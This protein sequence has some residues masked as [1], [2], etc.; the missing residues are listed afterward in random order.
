MNVVQTIVGAYTVA[1]FISTFILYAIK[2]CPA[3]VVRL[4]IIG[5]KFL[6]IVKNGDQQIHAYLDKELAFHS[7]SPFAKGDACVGSQIRH[8]SL[9][10]GILQTVAGCQP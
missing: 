8:T 6:I 7:K 9:P 5:F 3:Q 10:G 1:S 2:K 4:L